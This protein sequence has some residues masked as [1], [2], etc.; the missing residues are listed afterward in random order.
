MKNIGSVKED[1]NI[2]K[3][4]SITPET[5]KKFV[6]LNFSVFIEKNYGSHLGISDEEY[7]DQGANFKNS[8]KEVLEKT[9]IILKVNYPPT[10][11]EVNLIKE[12][13]ILIGQ[14]DPIVNNRRNCNNLQKKILKLFHLIYFQELQELN[15]WM[16]YLH[17]QI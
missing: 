9:E 2:E 13:S 10:G 11:Q 14:F 4:I 15:R 17:K 1:L 12:K 5:V 8:A 7:V 6:D 16:F 3:R